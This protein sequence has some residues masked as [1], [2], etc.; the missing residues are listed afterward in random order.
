MGSVSSCS[1]L[2]GSRMYKQIT[3][4]PDSEALSRGTWS[5]VRKSLLNQTTSM[6]MFVQ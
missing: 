3:G 6:D 5:L 2:S 1:S 4:L